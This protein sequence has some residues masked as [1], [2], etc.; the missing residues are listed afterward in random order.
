MGDSLVGRR[1][2]KSTDSLNH[3]NQPKKPGNQPKAAFFS[4]FTVAKRL[5]LITR[6][7]R[8]LLATAAQLAGRAHSCC[9][10]DRY[11]LLSCRSGDGD[12]FT[13][14]DIQTLAQRSRHVTQ[15][16]IRIRIIGVANVLLLLQDATR[17]NEFGKKFGQMKSTPGVVT[18]TRAS[19]TALREAT[20]KSTR[21]PTRNARATMRCERVLVGFARPPRPPLTLVGFAQPGAH[22]RAH[23]GAHPRAHPGSILTSPHRVG[24]RRSMRK[25]PKGK[26][27]SSYDHGS[28]SL[29]RVVSF[30]DGRRRCS[31]VEGDKWEM[32]IHRST[33]EL[34][35]GQRH[36]RWRRARVHHGDP[37]AGGPRQAGQ[38]RATALH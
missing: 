23:P 35:A 1:K 7:Y 17:D 30:G 33:A 19:C 12:A 2:T 3:T 9:P 36:R 24:P 38:A 18:L 25:N 37:Q 11:L 5:A 14:T 29:R 28:P 21:W 8:T 10:V 26:F 27:D 32:F 31:L 16:M 15:L 22:P 34:R 4:P 6:T 20:E 13:D